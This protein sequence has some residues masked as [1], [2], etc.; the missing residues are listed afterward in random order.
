VTYPADSDFQSGVA[1]VELQ[2]LALDLDGTKKDPNVFG[3]EL[4]RALLRHLFQ[5]FGHGGMLI[6][7]R[8]EA[9]SHLAPSLRQ[10]VLIFKAADIV[11]VVNQQKAQSSDVSGLGVRLDGLNA[12]SEVLTVDAHDDRYAKEKSSSAVLLRQGDAVWG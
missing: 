7:C 2:D 1:Q 10:D 12:G 6:R 4:G 5:F 11:D 9:H 8:L 3:G